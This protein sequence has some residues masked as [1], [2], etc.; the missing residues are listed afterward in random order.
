MLLY[1][2]ESSMTIT[3]LVVLIMLMAEKSKQQQNKCKKMWIYFYAIN[4]KWTNPQ[5]RK[6]MAKRQKWSTT[7]ND[8]IYKEIFGPENIFKDPFHALSRS[9]RSFKKRIERKKI[10]MT[11][12]GRAR[13][14]LTNR[15]LTICINMKNCKRWSVS[16]SR[17][18]VGLWMM[19]I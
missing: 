18:R 3:I 6:I 9:F 7:K 16:S 11:V 5:P 8:N 12:T 19:S 15:T 13:F 4:N 14:L 1:L 10:Q 17:Y 2:D